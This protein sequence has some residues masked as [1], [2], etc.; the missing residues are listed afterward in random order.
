MGVANSLLRT[1][2]HLV[3]DIRLQMEWV[4]SNARIPTYDLGRFGFRLRSHV[5]H[6]LLEVC[7]AVYS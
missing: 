2:W 6:E 1:T 7:L 4:S 3:L 5:N